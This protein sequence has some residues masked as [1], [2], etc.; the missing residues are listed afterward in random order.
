M[1]V[2]A[3]SN[4]RVFSRASS[5]SA[6][7]GEIA[8]RLRGLDLGGLLFFCGPGYDRGE[9]G[10]ALRSHFSCP[11]AG[12]TTAG[13]IIS[14]EGYL[15]NSLVAVG[16]AAEMFTLTPILIDEL[17]EQIRSP[18]TLQKLLSIP[19]LAPQTFG[20]LL[21]DGI[22]QLEDQ[23][24]A[25]LKHFLRDTPMVGGSA[26]DNLAFA[27]SFVYAEGAFH[28]DAAVLTLFETPLAAEP[29][30]IQHFRPTDTRLVV[31]SASAEK[32]VVYE[33]NGLPAVEVYAGAI[34]V[35]VDELDQPVFA[36]HPVMLRLAGEYYIRSILRANED[37]SL[38]FYCAID[39]GLVFTLA[40]PGRILEHLQSS[41]ATICCAFSRVELVL[42]CDCI[43]RRIE[44]KTQSALAGASDV[45]ADYP[46]LGFS[47]YGE[48][49]NSVHINH[50]LTGIAI[51]A[52]A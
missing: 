46:F 25:L 49:F 51:G 37:L 4:L 52:K 15:E 26:G 6:V 40:S 20:F 39:E 28:E 48:Q 22:S 24:V 35:G 10:A 11:V 30:R 13:E 36:A 42:G 19:L 31:T 34:G 18:E 44:L 38:S 7:V 12:C 21:T 2:S 16:F 29:F 50:T 47:T 33:I 32:R 5:P 23:L 45:L 9:L 17:R 1:H 3:P 27:H 8:E 43:L 14:P 41:L